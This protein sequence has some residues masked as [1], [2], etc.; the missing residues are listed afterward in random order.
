MLATGR[1]VDKTLIEYNSNNLDENDEEER[2]SIYI[3]F[4]KQN[5]NLK[6]MKMLFALDYRIYKK[7]RKI[8]L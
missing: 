7:T 1:P 3:E 8:L 5:A 6:M 4:N 2:K